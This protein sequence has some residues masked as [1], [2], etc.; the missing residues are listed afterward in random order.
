[1]VCMGWR[2]VLWLGTG[3]S[4]KVILNSEYRDAWVKM[5]G[6]GGRVMNKQLLACACRYEPGTNIL[7]GEKVHQGLVD[8]SNSL[9]FGP[10]VLEIQA[11]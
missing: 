4:N 1:M 5:L 3:T 7:I 8:P 6:A 2:D 11:H 10:N 9:A